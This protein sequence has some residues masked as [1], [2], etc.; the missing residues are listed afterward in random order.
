MISDCLH[1]LTDTI[2]LASA[3]S[4]LIP[5][6]D[7]IRREFSS[8]RLRVWFPPSNYS[9]DIA[10]TLLTWK[11]KPTLMKKSYKRFE[12]AIMNDIVGTGKNTATIPAE[13]KAKQVLKNAEANKDL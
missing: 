5:P 3:D 11:L 1:G 4:D 13:W 2:V 8:V 6:L 10:D 12:N 9:N 7:L